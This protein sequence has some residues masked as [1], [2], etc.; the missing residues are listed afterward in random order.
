MS[1]SP[2][3]TAARNTRATAALT[4]KTRDEITKMSGMEVKDAESARA[5]LMHGAYMVEGAETGMDMLSTVALQPSQMQKLPKPAMEAFRALAFLIDDAHQK[6][7]GGMMTDLV[8]KSLDTM[9]GRAKSTMEEASDNLLSAAISATNTMDE[10]REECQRLTADLKEATEEAAE[11]IGEIPGRRAD[12][13][14]E[15]SPAPMGEGTYADRVR[16]N[17]APPPPIH[18]V[19]IAR[20]EMQK[21]RVQLVKAAGLEGDGMAEL[22][23]KQLVEKANVALDLMGLQAEDKPK[24]TR[25]VG[26]SKLNGAGGVMYEMDSEGAAEWLK[27][28]DVMK[29]FI[30]KMGS[31][32][33]Y[34]AQTYEVVVDWVPTTLDMGQMGAL[35][36]IEQ[37]SGLQTAA[38][39]EARWIKPVHLRTPGQRTALAIFGFSTR[40]GANHAIGFGLFVE[41]KKVWARKQLQEPRRCLKC[42]CF[43]EHRAA[44]CASI[45]EVCGRC[46]KQHR[47]S[48]CQETD[49]GTF[50][51]SNC[52]TANN[53]KQGGHGAS[54]RRCPV[55]LERVDRVNHLCRE[56][57]Y[58][59]F[60]TADPKTWE[61]LEG[62][63][64]HRN[65]QDAS[66]ERDGNWQGGWTQG[67]TP[68]NQG[69]GQGRLAGGRRGEGGNWGAGDNGW[70]GIRTEG[71]RGEAVD[72]GRSR[73]M[74]RGGFG[75]GGTWGGAVNQNYRQET[76]RAG[77]P[78]QSTLDSWA[79]GGYGTWAD[80]MD[81]NAAANAH[82]QPGETRGTSSQQANSVAHA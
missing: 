59:F 20:G 14:R 25:F 65:F 10:F 66:W 76:Q 13:R 26:V 31:T 35:E 64:V 6:Q 44:K 24:G 47:T 82:A 46:A 30:A 49:Q 37:A 4:P 1:P 23:E 42:Q 34:R 67:N 3:V 38:I 27:G 53:G 70:V 62:G 56:N 63:E 45:H 73:E 32:A 57:K 19:V 69:G 74:G 50:T 12:E 72:R 54:D 9:L 60:C 36:S 15:K 55:F 41:G 43:G 79:T 16:R 48:D 21:R 18:A 8:E 71:L 11:M 68:H 5:Y 40:E 7:F 75:A 33:D 22:T 2:P 80:Q 58:R 81:A 61:T 28:G 77:G 29:A 51:C 17:T 39:R 52:K 78:I